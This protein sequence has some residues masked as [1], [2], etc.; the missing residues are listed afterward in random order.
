MAL[1]LSIRR[2]T[3][4]VTVHII[5]IAAGL[6]LHPCNIIIRSEDGWVCNTIY[7]CGFIICFFH[8]NRHLI[9]CAPRFKEVIV[10]VVVVLCQVCSTAAEA[11][12]AEAPPPSTWHSIPNMRTSARCKIF[13]LLVCYV[14]FFISIIVIILISVF[15][16]SWSHGRERCKRHFPHSKRIIRNA[17][18]QHTSPHTERTFSALSI[19]V[20]KCSCRVRI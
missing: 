20:M 10:V 1:S 3:A 12:G 9:L 14:R 17:D 6:P 4:F 19:T 16:C 5:C 11:E 8:R 13:V 15:I 7:R 18:G 2:A